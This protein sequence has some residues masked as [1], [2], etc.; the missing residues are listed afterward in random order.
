MSSVDPALLVWIFLGIEGL[1]LLVVLSVVAFISYKS[2]F[3]I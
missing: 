1:V 3:V 2:P